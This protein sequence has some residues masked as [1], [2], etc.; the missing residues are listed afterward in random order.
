MSTVSHDIILSKILDPLNENQKIAV[1]SRPDDRLQ[2]IA[3]P[4]TGK[5][6]VLVSR[7]AYLLL[8]EKIRPDNM[9]VTTFTKKAAMEMIH[10][11]DQLLEGTNIQTDKLIIG[12]FHSICY[13]IIRRY[14]K[15]LGLEKYTI[16]DEKDKTQIM[17]KMLEGLT[18]DELREFQKCPSSSRDFLK[19]NKSN[20]KYHGLDIPKIIREISS[21]K[22]KAMSPELYV[23]QYSHNKALAFLYEK[24]QSTLAELQK[25]D[26]DDCLMKCYL[27][28]SKYPVLNYIKHVLVDEFQDTNEIQLQL[29]YRFAQGHISDPKYQHNVTI[30]GDPDQSIYAF[31]DAQSF[32]F[33]KME[34][35]YEEKLNLPTTKVSLDENYRSTADILQ[36]SEKL[37][38]QQSGRHL[39]NLKS[40]LETSIKP[41]YSCLDSPQEEARWITYQIQHLLALP[42]SPIKCK[43]IAVLFRAAYQTRALESEL[44]RRKIPYRMIRGKAF[45]DRKEVVAIMDYLRVCGDPNDQISVIRTLNYPKR[46][47]GAKTLDGVGERIRQRAKNGETV[48]DILRSFANGTDPDFKL[49]K[50][51]REN[52]IDYVAMIDE[53]QSMLELLETSEDTQS[54]ANNLFNIVFT[55][56]SLSQEYLKENDRVLNVQEVGKQFTEFVPRDDTLP[57]YIDAEEEDLAE[58]DRNFIAKFIDSIGLYETDDDNDTK[59]DSQGVSLSTIHGSKGLEWPVVFVPGLSEGI[60]PAGFAVRNSLSA[61]ELEE[62]LNEER[63]CFYVATT[64]A[65]TLLYIS[66]YIE[67]DSGYSYGNKAVSESIFVTTLK[68][69]M[70]DHQ[71]AFA[72]IKTLEGLYKLLGK[73]LED[74]DIPVSQFYQNYVKR[75]GSYIAGSFKNSLSKK[76]VDESSTTDLVSLYGGFQTAHSAPQPKVNKRQ[77]VFVSKSEK[78]SPY[79]RTKSSKAPAYIPDRPR[80]KKKAKLDTKT[81]VVDYGKIVY[82]PTLDVPSSP[83]NSAPVEIPS[84]FPDDANTAP[85][86]QVY[87]ELSDN[88]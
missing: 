1:T 7:V 86:E 28:V 62:A 67:V 79:I 63:R 34:K 27:L 19:S 87:I 23:K 57:D 32:N 68:N 5:T 4:G 45:W 21:L 60:L 78:P 30:V 37:M 75:F 41:V 31:R 33:N 43:D 24:Y 72:N 56:S 10:R 50:K 14:G 82:P 46:G 48:H 29:M 49:S 51:I 64:R 83:A 80:A 36:L 55:K 65:K 85:K 58:D 61:T 9:I 18:Q 16:A 76:K 47:L 8:V 6:K 74:K 59:G 2:I 40:Q 53:V 11:L 73:E 39:K 81:P 25:V 38:R 42:G 17:Q 3:G 54:V 22:S 70:A 88:E 52:L 35:Y 77:Y 20:T 66:S 71:L 26:F 69:Q 15:V 12:T 84:M 13:R 44:V